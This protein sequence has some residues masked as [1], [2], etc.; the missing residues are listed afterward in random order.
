VDVQR[1]QKARILA[2]VVEI[3][4]D[5]GYEEV[6]VRRVARLAGVSTRTFYEHFD[7][8]E[9]C[10]LRTHESV[11]RQIASRLRRSQDG[12]TE[13]EERLGALLEALASV[14]AEEPQAARLALVEACALGPAAR[15]TWGIEQTVESTLAEILAAA[16]DD[17]EMS[18]LLMRGICSGI[19]G[20]VCSQLLRGPEDEM[21]EVGEQLSDWVLALHDEAALEL[22]DLCWAR[23]VELP[24]RSVAS[25]MRR[26]GGSPH[27][28]DRHLLLTAAAKLS[29]T[30]G[31]RELT[32]TQIHTAAG[33]SRRSFDGHFESVE[34]CFLEAL[35][36]GVAVALESAT[37]VAKG[38]EW[39][40][41]VSLAIEALC[42]QLVADSVLAK[43]TLS[44]VFEAGPAGMLRRA[45]I[46][47]A[48]A[49]QVFAA[50]PEQQPNPVARE[51]SVEA[52]WGALRHAVASRGQHRALRL[53]P[54]LSYLILAPAVGG[55]AA[56]DEILG[57]AKVC[58]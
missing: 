44:E 12:L 35:D 11:V 2:A 38:D 15:R 50:A 31:Y 57:K 25:Y 19:L 6:A 51:A 46:T 24:P 52:A 45:E 1:H 58:S 43:L 34:D 3:V 37:E 26:P 33:V 53:A 8:K 13:W 30:Q 7:G 41:D 18:P 49:A 32:S 23:P 39:V 55:R 5:H 56:V 20:V 21:A 27:Q 36:L 48:I 54:M 17:F 28:E 16:P 22:E 9:D 47:T 4:S 10:F 29:A 42:A 40:E 14:V